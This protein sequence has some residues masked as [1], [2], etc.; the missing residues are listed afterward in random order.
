MSVLALWSP[1]DSMLG[2]VG[3]LGAAAAV[4][5][6]LAIDLDPFGPPYGGPFS[7][8]D[9]VEHGPTLDQ[10][11]PARSGPAVLRNGGVQPEDA[12]E[13]VSELVR[14]WP[15]VVLRCSPSTDVSANA[16]ALLPLLPEP[17]TPT[18][19]GAGAVVYQ[20]TRLLAREPRNHQVLPV[21]RVAT[22]KSLLGGVRPPSRDRWVRAFR[23][24]WE[25]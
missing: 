25:L 24:V 16:T 14:R 19:D 13:I 22:V 7:L 4:D 21:P 23:D 8:A 2:I 5:T 11:E 15:N 3:P 1:L 9:L 6:A 18:L 12:E 10:L 17:F 20:R